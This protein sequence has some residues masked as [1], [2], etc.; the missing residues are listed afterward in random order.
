MW[1]R[2]MDRRE[3]R[4]RAGIEKMVMVI[5]IL[6]IHGLD[7]G[8]VQARRGQ[9]RRGEVVVV[10]GEQDMKIVGW[11]ID[12]QSLDG[13]CTPERDDSTL[14]NS[15]IDHQWSEIYTITKKYNSRTTKNTA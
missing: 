11:N 3:L 8:L 4:R 5:R 13:C 15:S 10:G 2:E 6:A 12:L 1:R 14:H 7:S 9:G